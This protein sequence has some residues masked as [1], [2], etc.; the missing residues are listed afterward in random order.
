M[1]SYQNSKKSKI[2]LG[3]VLVHMRIEGNKIA[4]KEAI[5]MQEMLKTRK[6]PINLEGY[7][8]IAKELGMPTQQLQVV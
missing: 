2:I 4:A 5:D 3:K 7:K 1:T 6:I 8:R